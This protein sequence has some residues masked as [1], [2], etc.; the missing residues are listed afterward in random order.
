MSK[1]GWDC[2]QLKGGRLQ[3]PANKP[4]MCAR[5]DCNYDYCCD[6]SGPNACYNHGGPRI[7]GAPP[8]TTGECRA[9]IN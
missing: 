1:D 5:R 4:V 8:I 9:F 6:Y 3:C 7:C 2:C